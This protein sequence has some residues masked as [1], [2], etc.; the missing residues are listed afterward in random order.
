MSIGLLYI[1]VVIFMFFYGIMGCFFWILIGLVVFD[2]CVDGKLLY[3]GLYIILGL[4]IFF[5]LLIG[6]YFFGKVF[7]FLM[8]GIYFSN[9]WLF[10]IF[11]I[12]EIVG[13]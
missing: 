2:L 12:I 9:V 6:N 7:Y 11:I 4:S 10:F 5:F 13:I 1:E 8:L 3:M